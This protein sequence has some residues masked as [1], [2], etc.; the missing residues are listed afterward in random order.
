MTPPDSTDVL[1]IPQRS[2][3]R[4]PLAACSALVLVL[5]ACSEEP[6]VTSAP[7]PTPQLL[8][9]H[10]S[11]AVGEPRVI[12]VTD[13]LFVAIGYDLAN[14][15]VLHT[16][17][18]NVV[19]DA[20]MSPERAK[21]ARAAI[22]EVA[23][24]PTKALV[25]THSHIDHVGGASEWLDPG[26]EVWATERFRDHFIKQYGVFQRAERSRGVRQFARNVDAASLQCSA[27]GRR[28]DFDLHVGGG[29]RMPTKTFSGSASFSVGGV[30]IELIEAHGETDDQLFVW[31]ESQQALLPGD[32]Y[33]QAFPNLYTIR[34]TKARPVSEWIA[35]LDAMR[36]REAKHLI[37]SHT[38]PIT[39]V[40]QVREALTTYRD[41]IAFVRNAVVQG[42]NAGKS[43][44]ELADTIRLPEHLAK[45][46]ALAE[47]YGQVDWSVRA[48]Y[49]NE[50]GWFDGLPEHLYPLPKLELTKREIEAMGGREQVLKQAQ[51]ALEQGEGRWAVHL[52]HKLD[53]TADD[54]ARKELRPLLAKAGRLVAKDIYNTNGRGYLLQSALE[55]EG[56]DSSLKPEVS[57][58]L[59]AELPVTTFFDTMAT[60]LKASEASDVHETLKI[61]L[62]DLQLEIFITVRKGVAEIAVGKALP[63]TPE[64]F[65]VLETDSLTWK[66][67]AL[68]KDNP[69]SATLDKRLSIDGDLLR[70]RRFTER[71][72]KGL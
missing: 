53:I 5:S 24:G 42:A 38:V 68:D 61:K 44:D 28:P 40:D 43:I 14:T 70:V 22:E 21:L 52:L 19:V 2:W 51:A 11:Q 45:A 31:I 50:L 8:K 48:I 17:D 67:M 13:S 55:Y 39:G 35:S 37:P 54:A 4:W 47:L 10:C 26:T 6:K 18:G 30:K 1:R 33:Y 65:A 12:Q 72:Q 23:P 66:R 3:R 25:F 69:L 15:I 63:S 57:D 71:F 9:D 64:P 62:T 49:D 60:R 36:Q 59:L 34:G 56:K 41:G 46:P 29:V 32:N 27:L 16:P 58:T 7:V 20:M